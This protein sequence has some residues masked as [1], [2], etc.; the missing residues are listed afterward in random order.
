MRFGFGRNWADFVEKHYSEETVAASKADLL[1]FL[2]LDHLNN[3]QFLDIGCGSGL[4]SLAALKA[5]A[6]KVVSFDFDS[7]SVETT[8]L[9]KRHLGNPSNWEVL[10]GSILDDA[11]VALLDTAD[12]VYAWGVLHHTGDVWH[13]LENTKRLMKPDG[14]LFIALYEYDVVTP[15]AEFWLDI[16]QKYNRG[17]WF[18][19][20]RY[21]IWYIWRFMMEGKFRNLPRAIHQIRSRKDRG[22][23]FYNDL[24]DWLGGW[25]MEFVKFADVKQWAEQNDLE[26]INL[27]Y[28]KIANTE[29]LF[30]YAKS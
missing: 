11:F 6:T 21:E 30:K 8:R 26:I 16:K 1:G 15:S 18:T 29:Y 3:R 20:R 5:G 12:I 17:G 7:N 10:Q 27:N 28:G 25:P 24:V 4:S 9:L 19:K 23:A 14:L 22:M 2:K 13:A